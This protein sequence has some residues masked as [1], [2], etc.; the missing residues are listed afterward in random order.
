[1]T[2]RS[3]VAPADRKSDDRGDSALTMGLIP[4]WCWVQSYQIILKWEWSCLH[5]T[6][7]KVGT[8]KHNCLARCQY[9]VTGWVSMWACDML[10]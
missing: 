6:Q 7:D 5:G 3:S 8:S 4:G 9:N 2:N 1:M 10:S